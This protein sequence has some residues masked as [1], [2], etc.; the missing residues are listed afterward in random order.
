[1]NRAAKQVAR[2]VH[3]RAETLRTHTG[4]PRHIHL[5]SDHPEM[6]ADA[7]K[8]ETAVEG[9][10]SDHL[11]VAPHMRSKYSTTYKD[12]EK[13]WKPHYFNRKFWNRCAAFT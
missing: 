12:S 3:E 7:A 4:S 9:G 10:G 5:A 13:G 11:S 8:P 1:M 2:D 6:G